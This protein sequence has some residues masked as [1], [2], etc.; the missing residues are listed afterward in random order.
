MTQ[1][2]QLSIGDLARRYNVCPQS[3]R[4]WEKN[5]TI[6]P[7]IRTTGGHRRFG[8]PHIDALDKILNAVPAA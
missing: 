7:A 5:G 1:Q 3:I 2:I 4:N 8:Q 6:P